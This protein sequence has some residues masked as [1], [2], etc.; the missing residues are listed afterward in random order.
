MTPAHAC[1]RI[2][3]ERKV[4]E[5]E[6]DLYA[7]RLANKENIK[8]W[9]AE[10][11]A[12]RA[13]KALQKNGF[14]ALHVP[15]RHHAREEILKLAPETGTVGVGGSMT[16]R[17]IGVLEE[18]AKH[19]HTIYDHWK[20]GLSP[21]EILQIRRAQLTCDVFLTSAN[22]L[23]L[24]G[25]LVS[26]DGIG[27]RVCAMTFGPKKVIIA[28]GTNKIVKN[29]EAGLR[30]V[31]EVAA[32]HT[33]KETGLPIPCVQTGICNDC[34]SP[35]RMCRATMILERKPLQTDITVLVIGEE[36]GF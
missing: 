5:M 26:T 14:D 15:D 30:R 7:K 23:T 11:R 8:Q 21:E 6:E 32:P 12:Q 13:M 27:N 24:E 29:I 16:I 19:G 3:Q 20:P 25:E 31:K 35:L 28:C 34:D 22:A 4:L 33:L 9:F 2:E 36:L 17:E 10:Q 18:L 1:N